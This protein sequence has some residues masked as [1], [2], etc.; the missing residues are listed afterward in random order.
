M[1]DKLKN[2]LTA[3]VALS[4]AV[5]L[6]SGYL[7]T[8][9]RLKNQRLPTH[10]VLAALSNDTYVRVAVESLALLVGVLAGVALTVAAAWFVP[11]ARNAMAGWPT[12]W[13]W[14][15]FGLA[16][17]VYGACFAGAPPVF[18]PFQR[19]SG[20]SLPW[21]LGIGA[22]TI[23]LAAGF[24]RLCATN[25]SVQL[26]L[27]L[28]LALSVV[29]ASAMKIVDAWKRDHPLPEATVAL[30]ASTCKAVPEARPVPGGCRV[31]GFYIA[32][33]D[34]WIYL[35]QQSRECTPDGQKE[36]VHGRLVLVP[37]D[38]ALDI[39]VAEHVAAP[40]KPTCRALGVLSGGKP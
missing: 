5:L 30:A 32:E 15:L 8:W 29:S 12:W 35:V 18:A 23:V 21:V 33:N 9:A 2:E 11:R 31:S 19:G 27:A 28:V 40:K 25:P 6:G 14:A 10:P 22:A 34:K 13:M 7:I 26:G 38:D 16:I 17:S 24:G 36:V 20:G 3:A 1:L 39:A 37:R 4:V